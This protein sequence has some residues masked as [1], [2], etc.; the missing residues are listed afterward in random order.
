VP[1]TVLNC[2][3]GNIV[4]SGPVRT[5][6]LRHLYNSTLLLLDR[7]FP[8]EIGIMAPLTNIDSLQKDAGAIEVE[9]VA[10][11]DVGNVPKD[12]D[13]PLTD[14]EKKIVKRATYDP[15]CFP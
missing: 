5:T 13:T 10:S 14:E 2:K 12:V 11:L 3:V 9:K 4:C 7:P 1:Q 15:A 6:Y 8:V